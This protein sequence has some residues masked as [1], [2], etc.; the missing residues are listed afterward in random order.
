MK[1]I[2][3]IEGRIAPLDRSDVDTDQI[4]PAVYLKRVERTGFG[5]GLF[6]AWRESDPGFVLNRP[7]FQDARVFGEGQEHG[8]S[9]RRGLAGS[10]RRAPT[11]QGCL[12]SRLNG[13]LGVVPQ[14][15]PTASAAP[16][17]SSWP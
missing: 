5:E 2:N 12:Q 3:K 14:S 6:A 1:P 17:R 16:L 7:E 8:R 10:A 9:S 4:I 11:E 15:V 13:G